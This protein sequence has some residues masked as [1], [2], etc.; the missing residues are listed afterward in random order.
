MTKKRVGA[1]RRNDN[2]IALGNPVIGKDEQRNE[3]LCPL[4]E[5]ETEVKAIAKKY[6]TESKVLIGR[7]AS[8]KS[9]KA[10]APTCTRIHLATHGVIDNR[11]PLYSH[12][13]L[14]K[15]NNDP[16]N[17]GLLEAREIMNMDLRADLA[18]LSACETAN[19]RI[20]EGEGVV[21]M[22]WAFFVAGTRSMLV[23]QWK[24]NS[25]STSQLMVDFYQTL[26]FSNVLSKSNK[27]EA[28]QKAALKL[29]RSRQYRHPFYWAA[30][31]LIG[32]SR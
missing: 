9:F 19:G 16:E 31:V 18:V 27:A 6:G 17:D 7:D 10:L 24:V 23:S 5:A 20:R 13:L 30:F 11:Q 29:L 12:L 15:T 22:S 8:E 26:G 32:D 14:T 3:E 4:P 25:A 2:L 1:E 21:G 28:L